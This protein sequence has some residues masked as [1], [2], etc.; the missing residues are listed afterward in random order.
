MFVGKLIGKAILD[1]Q[2][3]S[4]HFSR[5]VFKLICGKNIVYED[6]EFID[7]SIFLG[8]NKLLQMEDASQME[9]SF[10]TEENDFGLNN[11]YCLIDDG[12]NVLVTEQNKHK[13]AELYARWKLIDCCKNQLERILGGIFEIIPQQYFSIWDEKELE[14]QR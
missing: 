5:V 6:L 10:V 4:T 11:T 2:M 12:E 8:M 13:F 7:P 3:M 1:G 14:Q 9:M